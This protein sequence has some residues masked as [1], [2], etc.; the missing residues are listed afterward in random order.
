[1][2]TQISRLFASPER[3]EGVVASLVKIGYRKEALKVVRAAGDAAATE[4]ALRAAGIFRKAAEAYAPKVAAGAA[5]VVAQAPMGWTNRTLNV[6]EAAGPL[7]A[8]VAQEEVFLRS[9]GPARGTM[10]G[11]TA[12]LLHPDTLFFTSKGASTTFSTPLFEFLGFPS[13]L[14]RRGGAK[15]MTGRLFMTG[16]SLPTG[17]F[18]AG[19]GGAL[20]TGKRM[21]GGNLVSSGRR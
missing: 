9:D 8:G 17:R 2:T 6:M 13:L 21:M 1:M 10:Y 15:L 14:P 12:V 16:G 18:F 5:L 3:A 7:D 19:G 4:G 11:P 20:P